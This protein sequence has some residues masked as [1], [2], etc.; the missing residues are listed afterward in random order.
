MKTK[1]DS[2]GGKTNKET[3]AKARF[4]PYEAFGVTAN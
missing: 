2:I 1:A 3:A 4:A